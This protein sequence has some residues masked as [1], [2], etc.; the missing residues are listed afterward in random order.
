[1]RFGF[2]RVAVIGLAALASGCAT[3]A[4]SGG[5]A[6]A[7]SGVEVTR[8]HL[9][10]DPA[11]GVIAVEAGDPAMRGSM[12]FGSHSAAV[13]R[14]LARLGWTVVP[15]SGRS[16]QVALVRV[17]QGV[18]QGGGRRSGFS[19]GVGGGFGGRNA[20]VGGGV[21]IPIGGARPGQV[22]VTELAVRLQRRSDGT[23]IWEG[24][25]QSE[26]LAGTPLANPAAAVNRLA[27]ALFQGFP[28]ESGRTIRLP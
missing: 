2:A 25:A 20:G 24:R 4:G 28:G 21:N 26:A 9:G 13:A 12:E 10:N 19:V 6:T 1:M 3:G 11:R 15:A 23:S 14:E 17:S 22:V 8:F 18:R 16:E 27:G 7:A 5:G